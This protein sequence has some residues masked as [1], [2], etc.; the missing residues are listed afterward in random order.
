MVVRTYIFV[1][2][3]MLASPEFSKG[4][5]SP[6][7]KLHVNWTQVLSGKKLMTRFLAC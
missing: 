7:T 2:V 1:A 5:Y 6:R 4:T 3:A